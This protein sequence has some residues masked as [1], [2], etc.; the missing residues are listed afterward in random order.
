MCQQTTQYF[1]QNRIVIFFRKLQ[2]YLNRAVGWLCKEQ[3]ILQRVLSLH[4]GLYYN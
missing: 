3:V 2:V 1:G 4:T